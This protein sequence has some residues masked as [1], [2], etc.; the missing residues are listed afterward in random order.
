MNRVIAHCLLLLFPSFFAANS[1]A[2]DSTPVAEAM[3]T[4]TGTTSR[5]CRLL[6]TSAAPAPPAGLDLHIPPSRESLLLPWKAIR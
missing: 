1:W 2:Q 4:R 6:T 3:T 5:S